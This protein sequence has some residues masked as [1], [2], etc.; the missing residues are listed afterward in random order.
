MSLNSALSATTL[1]GLFLLS[2][3]SNFTFD[4]LFSIAPFHLLGRKALI[5]VNARTSAFIGSI[6]P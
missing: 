2:I 3:I 5:G 6:G 1:T 4:S